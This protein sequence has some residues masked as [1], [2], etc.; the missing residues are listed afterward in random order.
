M[1]QGDRK[2]EPIRAPDRLDSWKEIAAYLNR[3]ERTVRRWE[4]TEELPV[5]RL[6][7]DKRGSVYAFR[8][9]LDAWM[10]A[11]GA[12]LPAERPAGLMRPRYMA[13]AAVALV[14]GVLLAWWLMRTPGNTAQPRA[15]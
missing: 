9:E 7:H 4:A 8:G 12:Q 15:R 13:A 10:A 5:H 2:I 1:Q 6:Q 11:R 14:L 3:S